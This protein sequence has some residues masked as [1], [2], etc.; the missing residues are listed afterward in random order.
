MDQPQRP[1]DEQFVKEVL[2]WMH[3][4]DVDWQSFKTPEALFQEFLR[5]VWILRVKATA[6]AS[7]DELDTRSADTSQP[8]DEQS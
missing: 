7:A 2:E 4:L 6:G 1:D 3:S 8:T 5:Q